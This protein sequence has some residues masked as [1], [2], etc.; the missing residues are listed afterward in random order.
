[1]FRPPS[2]TL[3]PVDLPA[4]DQLVAM[5]Q[6]KMPAFPRLTD[7]LMAETGGHPFYLTETLRWWVEQDNPT[8]QTGFLPPPVRQLILARLA[9]LT[10]LVQKLLIAMAVLGR[11]CRFESLCQIANVEEEAALTG[12]DTLLGRGLVVEMID[13]KYPY[14]LSHDK[15]RDVVYTEAGDAQRRLYHRRALTALEKNG[16][17]AA[18]LA[19]HALAAY[20]EMPAFTYSLQAGNEALALFAL[21]EAIAHYENA[22][23]LLSRV[24]ADFREKVLIQLSRA[25]ELRGDLAQAIAIAREMYMGSLRH[26][27]KEFT[28]LSRL[29]QLHIY[30]NQLAKASHY[31]GMAL[32]LAKEQDQLQWQAEVEWHLAQLTQHLYQ[33]PACKQHS[34]NALTLA[35]QLK[36]D[37]LMASSLNNLGYAHL[38]LGEFE[39]AAAVLT[40]AQSRFQEMG[41]RA[42]VADCQTALGG[43]AIFQGKSEQGIRLTEQALALY[44]EIENP[45]GILFSSGW[46]AAGLLDTSEGT[47]ALARLQ[48]CTEFAEF[49]GATPVS[50]WHYLWLGNAHRALNQLNEAL[51][52]HR[53]A[54]ILNEASPLPAFAWYIAAEL[55]ADSLL[56]DAEKTAYLHAQE[57][58]K[59]R[60]YDALPQIILPQWAVTKALLLGGDSLLAKKDLHKN[61]ALWEKLSRFKLGQAEA[62]ALLAQWE[63]EIGE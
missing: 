9:S 30:T 40:E 33:M 14:L 45:W 58:L 50:I 10:P 56:M 36:N 55:C 38:L 7:W 48:R 60:V 29:G 43:V 20:L 19:R 51:S 16:V 6:G 41:N 52:A 61:G 35:R 42:L 25:Y 2:L 34:L 26:I 17:K 53:Q 15:I 4:V 8:P 31:L 32:K 44:R 59:W 47:E 28:A 54:A 18:E 21:N 39:Q 1:M 49:L 46:L 22:K 24:D 57:V 37:S 3:L 13:R 23:K 12:L 63:K 62:T 11:P 5:W 27:S